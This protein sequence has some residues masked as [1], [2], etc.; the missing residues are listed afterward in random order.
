MNRREISTFEALRWNTNWTK[1]DRELVTAAIDAL[2]PNS[3]LYM[4]TSGGYIAAERYGELNR[5]NYNASNW[6][7]RDGWRR[8]LIIHRGHIEWPYTVGEAS[9][10]PGMF[11]GLVD[12]ER[13]AFGATASGLR[14]LLSTAGGLQAST[15]TT[16]GK[17]VR[18]CPRCH[19]E[20][21][22]AGACDNCGE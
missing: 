6:R 11:P 8:I 19:L 15:S 20:L 7:T 17:V 14:V 21:S 1:R 13:D 5:Q 3:V 18:A 4:P 12:F 9:P 22:V 10:D 16:S 2:P